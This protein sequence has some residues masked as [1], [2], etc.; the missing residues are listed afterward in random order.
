[1]TAPAGGGT[2]AEEIDINAGLVA[3]LIAAQHPDLAHM[4]VTPGPVGWDNQMFRL[5]DDLAVRMPKR[6]VAAPLLDR[7]QAWLPG[8]AGGLP[9]PVP[10]MLRRGEPAEGYP[11]TWSLLP[12]LAGEPADVAPPEPDQ[13]GAWGGFLKAL[14]QP[15]PADAPRNPYRG[16]PLAA[17]KGPVQERMARLRPHGVITP[18]IDEF[19]AM[20]LE[21]PLEHETWLHGDPHSRNVL[22][23]QGRF[24]AVI[25]W[26]DMCV[27]DPATDLASLWMLLETPLARDE[28][29]AAYG[30][31]SPATLIRARGWAVMFG[32]MLLD[33]GLVDD[34]R[35]AKAGRLTLERLHDG[36]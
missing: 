18:M 9:L 28:A 31:I 7:E 11:W 8:I 35:L 17:R 3:R 32:V 27:G 36:P 1:M 13:G 19:W 26:G 5:G 4:P 21:T 10:A 33:A 15:A 16:V 2:P 6:A 14:H 20:A 22:T 12:W 30:G 29:I 24:S 34:P 23:D 25:D